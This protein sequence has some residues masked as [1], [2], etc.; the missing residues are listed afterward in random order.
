M[1]LAEDLIFSVNY[2]GGDIPT[3]AFNFSRPA[4]QIVCQYYNVLRLGFEG[5][6]NIHGSCY[7]T[8]QYLAAEIGKMEPFR[9]IHDGL[10]GLPAVC[11]TLRHGTDYRFSLTIFPI[12]SVRADGRFRLIRCHPTE[13]T[14]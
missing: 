12:G 13:R 8:A 11:R 3:F 10:G 5:Y 4:G 1:D 2:L 9:I 7:H 14:S 6:R